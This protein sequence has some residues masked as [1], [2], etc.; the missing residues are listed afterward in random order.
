MCNLYNKK[1]YVIHIK[2][3]KKALDH[4]LRLKK[5]QGNSVQSR[6][7]V[8][9]VYRYGHGTVRK[10]QKYVKKDFFKLANH[11]VFGKTTKI[12][13]KHRNVKLM[14]TDKRRRYIVSH[15]SYHKTK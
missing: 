10:C 13:R 5:T 7:L 2:A 15:Q 11:S 4:G 8:E 9:V 12:V 3:L 14:T 6:K 1:N